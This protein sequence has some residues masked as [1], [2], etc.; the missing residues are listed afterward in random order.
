MKI[1]INSNVIFIL[2]LIVLVIPLFVSCDLYSQPFDEEGAEASAYIGISHPADGAILNA[3]ESVNITSYTSISSGA[4]IHMLNVNEVLDRTDRFES[5]FVGGTIYIPWIPPGPGEFVLQTI[6]EST[7]G[8]MAISEPITVYVVGVPIS[9]A[10]TAATD[11]SSPTIQTSTPRTATLT[12][13]STTTLTPEP[14]VPQ[15]T[16]NQNNNC[17]QGPST[18]Y[19]V[20]YTYS[21]GQTIPIIGRNSGI[22]WIVVDPP[23]GI[24]QC[25]IRIDLVDTLGNLTDL[26]VITAP[27]SPVTDTPERATDTPEPTYTPTEEPEIP[28]YSACSDYPDLATCN[29]DPMGFGNCIWDTG[30][31]RCTP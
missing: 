27:P 3:G 17:R 18:A 13:T 25:W 30:M 23:G 9:T 4:R 24:N 1:S 19:P 15:A 2:F 5:P 7:A 31:N 6:I 22:T 20:V 29:E 21:T 16:T 10:I 28:P 12:S 14:D 8:E 26:P 11:T